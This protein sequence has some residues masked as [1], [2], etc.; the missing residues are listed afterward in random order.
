MNWLYK[1]L[2]CITWSKLSRIAGSFF[3]AFLV[4]HPVHS[5]TFAS[6]VIDVNTATNK[7]ILTGVVWVCLTDLDLCAGRT[8]L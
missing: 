7:V 6:R 1:A 2:T 5:C 4:L 3:N 8:L